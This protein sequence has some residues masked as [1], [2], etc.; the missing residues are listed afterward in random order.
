MRARR[1]GIDAL[2]VAHEVDSQRAK[3]I[4]DSLELLRS[5]TS[6]VHFPPAPKTASALPVT[7]TV[8]NA[9]RLA[10]RELNEAQQGAERIFN[11]AGIQLSWQ[12]GLL[13][14]E[15]TYSRASE[16]RQP[17]SLHLGIWQRTAEVK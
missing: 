3:L 2:G 5:R 7:V 11:R 13:G 12:T 15:A 10:T 6:G 1:C 9:A 14:A 17:C 8:Y 4:R 16:T